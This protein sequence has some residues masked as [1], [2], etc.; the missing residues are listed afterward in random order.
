M[1]VSVRENVS[2]SVAGGLVARGDD[3]VLESLANNKGAQL[4]RA[5]MET[6][7]SR[8][9]ANEALQEPMVMRSDVPPDLLKMIYSH[10]S[11]ALRD[12]I[13][14]SGLDVSQMD[15]LMAETRD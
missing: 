2:E 4:S 13:L 10:V 1:E 12:H 7:M 5:A 11:S 8:A 15:G 6:M 3:A 14:N 9:E